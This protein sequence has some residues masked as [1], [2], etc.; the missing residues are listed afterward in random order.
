MNDI[1]EN[2]H[3]T[4]LYFY[5]LPFLAIT[6][7][8]I[9]RVVLQSVCDT[10]YEI[11]GFEFSRRILFVLSCTRIIEDFVGTY[12][13]VACG[14]QLVIAVAIEA[15]YCA[16]H[17][18]MIS[19]LIRVFCRNNLVSVILFFPRKMRV[20]VFEVCQLRSWNL[21]CYWICPTYENRCFSA[22]V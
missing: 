18:A 21:R 15:K 20:Q 10:D 17:F 19:Y 6:N 22:F 4:L 11:R 5:F 14:S 1:F 9:Y 3:L 13:F 7:C 16:H 2:F 12:S 8:P